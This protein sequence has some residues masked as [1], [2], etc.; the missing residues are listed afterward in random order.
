M[1]VT[2]LTKVLCYTNNNIIRVRDPERL[3]YE[4]QEAKNFKFNVVAVTPDGQEVR[5]AIEVWTQLMSFTVF[6]NN[7]CIHT[8]TFGAFSESV[9]TL[10][11]L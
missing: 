10:Q 1:A 11:V 2:R 5:S 9:C 7:V 8:A 6:T 3:D 4:D